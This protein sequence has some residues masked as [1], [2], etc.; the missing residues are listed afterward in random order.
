LK[1]NQWR[2][3]VLVMAMWAMGL[4][5]F[6]PSMAWANKAEP[7]KKS[8]AA[9]PSKPDKGSKAAAKPVAKSA[10]SAKAVSSKRGVRAKAKRT[11]RPARPSHGQ[12][13][14]LHRV[15]DPLEL[16]SNAAVVVDQ[17]SNEVLFSKNA[18]AVL[19]IASLTKLMT[20]I[21]VLESGRDLDELL[22]I[23]PDDVVIE[24]RKKSKLF[25]GASLSRR[26]LLHLA[27]MSSENRAARALSLNHPGGEPAFVADMNAKAFIIGMTNTRFVEATGLSSGNKASAHDL[28]ELVKAAYGFELIRTLSTSAAHDLDVGEQHVQY[29]NTNLLINNPSWRIGLQKTGYISA[30]GRCLVMQASLPGRKLVMVFLDSV[31]RHSRLGDAERVRRWLSEAP[32]PAIHSAVQGHRLSAVTHMGTPSRQPSAQRAG[33]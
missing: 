1:L 16:K 25:V 33:L 23:T 28:A 2:W 24:N 18:N 14:G 9:P 7:A 10:K 26:E 8:K 6:A 32:R 29:R 12:L 31:G 17:L 30:A 22:T 15:P 20:A 3:G 4:G 13:L 5:L 21:V 19:P 11:V 27:L